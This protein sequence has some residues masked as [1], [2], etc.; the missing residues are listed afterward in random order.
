MAKTKV[1]D[2]KV[3]DTILVG[4]RP[5]VVKEKEESDIGKHGT[6]KVRLVVDVGGKDMV[7]IRPSEYP[8][9]TA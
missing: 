3:G 1:G 9:E 6:K 7:I 5:G 8:I 4:G 2:L